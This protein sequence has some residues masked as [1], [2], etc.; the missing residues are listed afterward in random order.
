MIYVLDTCVVS[1]ISKQNPA[2]EVLSWI[3]NQS[4]DSLFVS[5]LTLGEI[6][7][8]IS[9]LPESSKKDI[10]NSWFQ[11]DCL[12]Q[13]KKRVLPVDAVVALINPWKPEL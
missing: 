6:E 10:L 8:G 4:D 9:K 7:K 2:Q 13:F 1:E 3:S 12:R 5:A 11:N